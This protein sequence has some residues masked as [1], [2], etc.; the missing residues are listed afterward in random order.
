MRCQ[1]WRRRAALR[2]VG[3]PASWRDRGRSDL[4]KRAQ[5]RSV[6]V[7]R[8]LRSGPE[9][10]CR[11]S[12]PVSRA[13]KLDGFLAVAPQG[14]EAKAHIAD[15]VLVVSPSGHGADARGRDRAGC[16]PY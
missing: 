8:W 13:S 7:T 12:L 1:R 9:A 2:L 5:L 15:C 11:S 10:D 14:V 4:P 3:R 16:A 6:L